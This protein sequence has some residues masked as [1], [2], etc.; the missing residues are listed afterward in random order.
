[1]E[2]CLEK[3]LIKNQIA[4][5]NLLCS[6]IEKLTG[7]T[8]NVFMEQEDGSLVKMTPTTS[9]VTWVQ[10]RQDSLYQSVRETPIEKL[11]DDALDVE[12]PSLQQFV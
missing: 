1:M 10:A 4:L 7:Q 9:F 11:P 12:M 3:Q 8:P 6:L 5:F 2:V